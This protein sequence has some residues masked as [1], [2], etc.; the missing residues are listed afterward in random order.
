[1]RPTSAHAP[2]RRPASRARPLL[3]HSAARPPAALAPDVLLSNSESVPHCRLVVLRNRMCFPGG[4]GG[5]GSPE[6]I[7]DKGEISFWVSP[8]GEES[9]GIQS[10][11]R[12]ILYTKF[13]DKTEHRLPLDIKGESKTIPRIPRPERVSRHRGMML[14]QAINPFIRLE[15]FHEWFFCRSKSGPVATLS[16][17]AMGARGRL[18]RGARKGE[19]AL[20]RRLRD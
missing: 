4:R 17:I 13:R 5:A 2:H 20:R 19:L 8:A 10:K 15:C 18:A 12:G 11:M 14:A 7:C 1:M 16:K 6:F 9:P 3:K